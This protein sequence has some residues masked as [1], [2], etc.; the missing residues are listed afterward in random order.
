M[1][2]L[3]VIFVALMSTLVLG[4][5]GGSTSPSEKIQL[6]PE[7][8]TVNEE[9]FEDQDITLPMNYSEDNYR[10]LVLAVSFQDVGARAGEISD[11]VVQTLST[12]L[13]TEMAKLKRFTIY[14]LHNRGGVR[15]LENLSDIGEAN[16][17]VPSGDDLPGIDLVLTGAI[18][19]S[20]E[21]HKRY[22]KEELVYE[23]EC[24][25]SCEEVATR[26]VRFAEKAK[27]RVIRSQYF[28]LTGKKLGGFDESDQRQAVYGAAMKA[29][30]VLA[31]KLG[32]TF[33]VGGEV[34]GVLGNRMNINRGYED[35]IGKD[36]QMV[37]Y[38]KIGGVDLPLGRATANPGTNNSNL[39][40]YKWN[41]SDK[42]AKTIIKRLEEELGAADTLDLYAVSAGM[43][44]PPEWESA[45]E[46]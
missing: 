29:L 42:Y 36:N 1:K 6:D 27:G 2:R 28:T 12:R 9:T 35:G 33:P 24:D 4:C 7:L 15:V 13:Q 46:N 38:A 14:S 5:A 16:I 22:D 37:V 39:L 44:V 21:R 10:K 23:V 43:S 8:Y 32:N 31:N 19:V 20:V 30:A 3:G 41:T 18:T 45:Y 26:T 40:V 34:T 17:E 11:D 25:F